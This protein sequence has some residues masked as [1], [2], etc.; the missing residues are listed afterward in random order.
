MHYQS[1]QI[2]S[3]QIDNVAVVVEAFCIIIIIIFHS[4]F[5]IIIIIIDNF[6]QCWFWPRFTVIIVINICLLI[7]NNNYEISEYIWIQLY[8]F[9]VFFFCL[10]LMINL[11]R[12][13]WKSVSLIIFHSEI[14]C[15]NVPVFFLLHLWD[16]E[17]GNYYYDF[18]I[19][20]G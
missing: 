1:N 16:N 18:R 8:G 12:N 17:I 10:F 13:I 4:F 2:K 19:I 6:S 5:L 15:L 20:S 14:V 9:T 7:S 11:S 3:N